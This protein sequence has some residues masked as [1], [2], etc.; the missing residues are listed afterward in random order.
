MAIK[1]K[2]EETPREYFYRVYNAKKKHEKWVEKIPCD[3][4]VYFADKNELDKVQNL[5]EQ[6]QKKLWGK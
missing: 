2:D 4:I 6:Q 5:I 1:K 3:A